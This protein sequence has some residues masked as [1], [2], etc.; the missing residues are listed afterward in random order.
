MILVLDSRITN[1]HEALLR[2]CN[3]VDNLICSTYNANFWRGFGTA[4]AQRTERKRKDFRGG[5]NAIIMVV[6]TVRHGTLISD[7]GWISR[8]RHT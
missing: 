1:D 3:I 5:I 6:K 8:S 2:Q 4:L 7:R